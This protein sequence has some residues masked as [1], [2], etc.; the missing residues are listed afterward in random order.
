MSEQDDNNSTVVPPQSAAAES[1]PG[2]DDK[3]IALLSH[4]LVIFT[5]FVGPLIIWLLKKDESAYINEQAKE[6]LNFS[7][8]MILAFVVCGLLSVILIGLLLMPLVG[9]WMVVMPIIA[10]VKCSS[11]E[12]YRYPLTLRL[13][14]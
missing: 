1:A 6:A 8:T 14:K 10:A 12:S 13:L 9:L 11:G 4:L 7:I 5:G 3:N 2:N